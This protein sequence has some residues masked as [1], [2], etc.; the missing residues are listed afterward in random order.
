MSVRTLSK[1]VA[2]I[3]KVNFFVLLCFVIV[4]FT[5]CSGETIFQSNFDTTPVNDP[6]AHNQQVGT[7]NIDGPSGSVKVVG[8]QIQSSGK[9]VQVARSNGQQSVSG[10]QCNFSKFIGNGEY[11]FSSDLFIPSGSGLVTIQFETFGQPVSTY[12]NFLHLDFTQDNKVRL[13]DNDDTKF[14]SFPRNQVFIVQVTIDINDKQPTAHIVLSGAGASGE[15][16]YNIQ[17]PFLTLAHQFGAVRLWMGFPWTGFFDA[18]TILVT[19]KTS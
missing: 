1:I 5:G 11:T 13:D 12:T 8:S 15:K 4:L 16:D 9:W 6:P 2:Q 10:L 18:T 7:A 14:G 17:T 19:H 3:F